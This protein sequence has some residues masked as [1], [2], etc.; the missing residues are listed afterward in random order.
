[1]ECKSFA[2][3]NYFVLNHVI[4]NLNQKLGVYSIFHEDC[5]G[6]KIIIGQP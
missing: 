1:M 5:D 6:I 4:L 2:L 3:V